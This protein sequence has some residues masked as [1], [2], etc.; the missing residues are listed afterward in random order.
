MLA[1]R[2]IRRRHLL[3]L[4][5]SDSIK[6]HVT[7]DPLNVSLLA[8]PGIF[9]PVSQPLQPGIRFFQPPNPARHQLALR[10][11]CPKGRRGWVPTFHITDPMGDLGVPFTPGTL[12]FS[13]GSY[14]TC[15]LTTYCSHKG[16]ALNLLILVGLSLF[17]DAYGH[18]DIFTISPV[19][20]P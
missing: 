19:P 2:T 8:E 4:L 3:S 14:K 5:S 11:A 18:S 16:A 13:A 1:E 20:S 6:S 9:H 15:N 7:R 10:L 12:Q 17:N